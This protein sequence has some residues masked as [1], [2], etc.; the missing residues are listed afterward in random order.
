M[1][2]DRA[3]AAAEEFNRFAERTGA[4]SRCDPTLAFAAPALSKAL[5]LWREKAGER[6]MPSRS[7]FSAR[8]LKAHLP[9]VAIV[10]AVDEGPGRRYRFRLMGT[11]IAG[12]LG[13]HTG[14]F[15]D[16]AVVSP[17]RERWTAVMDGP[18]AAGAPLRIFGRVD[19]NNMNF[20]AMELLLAPLRD[21][22]AESILIVTSARAADLNAF[23][24]LARDKVSAVYRGT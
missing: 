2:N 15:I 14:K 11:A 13:D 16:E 8:T 24:P 5:L 4:P 20:L 18:L 19:Y 21:D 9:H 22:G 1:P 7:D 17:F 3:L 6:D 23:K 12:L 10:D